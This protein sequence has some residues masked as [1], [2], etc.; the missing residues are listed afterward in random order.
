MVNII[1]EDA[2]VCIDCQTRLQKILSSDRFS[3]AEIELLEKPKRTITAAIPVHMDDGTTRTFNAYRVQYS[4]AR[5]PGKGGIRFHHE[6]HLSEVRNLA[7]LMALKCALIDVPF[8][9]AK[10]GVEVAANELSDIEKERLARG[11][12]REFYHVL[13]DRIDIPAPDMNTDELTMGWMVDEYARM[14]GRFVPGVVTGKPLALGGSRGRRESTA[15]GGVSVLQAYLN[16][17]GGSLAGTRVAVQGFGNVGA[18]IAGILEERGA[19]IVAISDSRRAIYAPDGL[20]IAGIRAQHEQG[21]LPEHV[22]A[23]EITNAELLTLP[24][25]VLVP[26]AISHQ[27]TPENAESIQAKIILEMANDPI[28]PDAEEMLQDR[29]IV[30]IP[31]ILANAGGVLVSYFEWIQNSSNEYWSLQKVNDEL[32]ERMAEAV[33]AVLA[34]ATQDHTSLRTHSYILAVERII[35]AERFRGRL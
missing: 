35:E 11:F 24:V 1:K 33:R 9:G 8:G 27:I 23:E 19:T 7:F 25:D 17:C 32:Q 22:E 28:T 15:L 2:N 18:N 29:E 16:E 30:V 26:A 12:V 13:G 20:S 34:V 21:T 4:D 14:A 6:V 5:G 10:G 31:D 3:P